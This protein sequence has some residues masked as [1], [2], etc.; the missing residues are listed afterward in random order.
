MALL[1]QQLGSNRFQ[2]DFDW[3][4]AFKQG[5]G[6][7]PRA[8]AEMRAFL[9]G[10]SLNGAGSPAPGQ[11]V[12]EA[13]VAGEEVRSGSPVRRSSNFHAQPSPR[14]P[15][16]SGLP[17]LFPATDMG[18]QGVIGGEQGVIGGQGVIETAQESSEE[19]RFRWAFGWGDHVLGGSSAHVLGDAAPQ[20]PEGRAP[21]RTAAEEDIALDE[22][23]EE[24]STNSL[25]DGIELAD[26]IDVDEALRELNQDYGDQKPGW[27]P[28]PLSSAWACCV[29]VRVR[30]KG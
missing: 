11:G 14:S 23:L 25:N 26:H 4:D 16:G 29:Q 7:T 22:M 17:S 20:P 13:P 1:E 10:T 21:R 18:E 2:I 3:R 5:P 9:A 28:Q 24:L 15:G 8:D 30:V 19:K 27:V 6:D 12:I